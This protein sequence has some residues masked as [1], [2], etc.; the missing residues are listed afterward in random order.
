MPQ[1]DD[2]TDDPTSLTDTVLIDQTVVLQSVV[3]H[4]PHFLRQSF[5]SAR[6]HL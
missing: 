3:G 1:S 2:E 6:G 5:I 4:R